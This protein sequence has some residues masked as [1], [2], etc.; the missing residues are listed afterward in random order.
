MINVVEMAFLP[1]QSTYVMQ[2][3]SK[4]Q[5]NSSQTREEQWSSTNEKLKQPQNSENNFQQ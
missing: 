3:P 4:F 1:N 2:V 5:H